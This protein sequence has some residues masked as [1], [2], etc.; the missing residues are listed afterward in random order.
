MTIQHTF[1]LALQHHQTGHLSQAEILY[2]QILAE[3]PN[4][5]D[6]LHYLGVLS[7]QCGRSDNAV[8]LID[9]AIALKPSWPEAHGNRGE[10]L[11]ILG[12]LDEAIAAHRQAIALQPGFAETYN[13]LG[14]ALKCKG[15]LDEAITTFRQAIDLKRDFP[16]ARY[17]L[18]IALYDHGHVDE[19]ITSYQQ[20]IAL[21]PNYPEAYS[22]LGNALKCKGQ[23]D[24]AIVSYRQAIALQPNLSEAY[25]NLSFALS[26]K[27]Q[28]DEAIVVCHHAITLN[29]DLPEAYSNLGNALHE[30]GQLD[31]AIAAYRQAIALKSN[32][33][34]AYR[35]L[36]NALSQKKWHADALLVHRHALALWPNDP[37]AHEA[38]GTTLLCKQ[39]LLAA[40]ASF[41]RAL[42]L[43]YSSA[44]L[45]GGLGF[46][47]MH[48]GRFEEATVCFRNALAISPDVSF[49]LA[50]V[51]MGQQAFDSAEIQRFTKFMN[52]PGLS[53]EDHI[54]AEFVLGKLLNEAQCF[55]EAF[56]HFAAV[57]LTIKQSLVAA[58]KQFNGAKLRHMVDYMIET[59]T[60]RFFTDRRA[61]GDAS[62]L[63]VFI[64]GMPRSGTSL[65]EQIAASHRNVHGA[66]E[67]PM[68]DELPL[69]M[70]S[71]QDWAMEQRA[72]PMVPLAWDASSVARVAQA[73]LA[74]L[75]TLGGAALRVIDKMPGNV[76]QLGL[77]AVLFPNARVIFCRRDARDTCLSCYFQKFEGSNLSYSYDLLDCGRQWLET[78]RLT[79]HWRKTLPLQMIEIQYEALVAD[80]EGQSRRL[81]DFLGLPWDPACLKF[82]NTQRPVLTASFWQVRQPIYTRSVGH[83]RHYERHLGPLLKLLEGQPPSI[84]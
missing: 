8:D 26:A 46:V 72:G 17:N 69:A 82:H 70:H 2:R 71:D 43:G 83:W 60:R 9:R 55:D 78:E 29:P 54:T 3:Q 73:Y 42:A 27:G 14:I 7:H 79:T 20:A 37:R 74:Q 75:R 45:W 4:H 41:R 33:P 57:N 51:H 16:Q 63:P 52:R 11:R 34:E 12:R 30:K 58:D 56:T 59:F 22:N 10:I 5:A 80:L 1:N 66:G 31:K 28:Y 18:G 61:W 13:N 68:I 6:A 21:Q 32:F 19:A 84:L 35:N 23:F 48:L 38:L 40:E 36:G 53:I 50:L 67:L 39:D 15:L 76:F 49:Y 65:I 64:V 62:E 24:E 47:L 81:I 44:Q 77:I 25:C